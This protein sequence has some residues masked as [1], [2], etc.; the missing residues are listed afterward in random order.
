[1]YKQSSWGM[2]DLQA[3]AETDTHSE[4]EISEKA[5]TS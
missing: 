5:P 2:M 4:S 1:M 3:L